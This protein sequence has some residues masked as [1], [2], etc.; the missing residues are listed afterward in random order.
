MERENTNSVYCIQYKRYLLQRRATKVNTHP[1]VLNYHFDLRLMINICMC[2]IMY[3][4]C[5]LLHLCFIN[6]TIER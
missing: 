2:V 5:F 3:I 6:T 4:L 1:D